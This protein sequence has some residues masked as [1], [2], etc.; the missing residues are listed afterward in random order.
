MGSLP[1]ISL[2]VTENYEIAVPSI[3]VQQEIV[4]VLDKFTELETELQK[5]LDARKKQY[6]YYRDVLLSFERFDE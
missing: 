5:E 4:R 3:E 6:I 1:Q 2:P